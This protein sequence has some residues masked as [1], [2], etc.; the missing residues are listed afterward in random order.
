MKQKRAMVLVSD[1][2]TSLLRGAQA[3]YQRFQE[4]IEAYDLAKK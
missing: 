2:K 4:E 1:D 3:V